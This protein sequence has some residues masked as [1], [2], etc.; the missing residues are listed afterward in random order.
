MI[1][2]LIEIEATLDSEIGHGSCGIEENE[3][4]DACLIK[5]AIAKIEPVVAEACKKSYTDGGIDYAIREYERSI[6]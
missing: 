1:K 6:Q 4:P 2:T 5:R 3:S